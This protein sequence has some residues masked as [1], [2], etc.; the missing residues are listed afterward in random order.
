[1]VEY[2][3]I[4]DDDEWCPTNRGVY[5][6]AKQQMMEWVRTKIDPTRA[7]MLMGMS[8]DEVWTGVMEKTTEGSSTVNK[9][10]AKREKDKGGA[11]PQQE[12]EAQPRQAPPP[13]AT[14]HGEEAGHKEAGAVKED[15]AIRNTRKRE[16]RVSLAYGMR[17]GRVAK[18]EG[19]AHGGGK[20]RK[21]TWWRER[22]CLQ[23]CTCQGHGGGP[24]TRA[25]ADM[26]HVVAGECKKTKGTTEYVRQIDAAM[27]KIEKAVPR[28][29]AVRGTWQQEAR[30][31]GPM[32]GWCNARR[33]VVTAKQGTA[34]MVEG[35]KV[36]DIQW[37]AMERF[38]SDF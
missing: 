5:R 12:K 33:V 24:D 4:G 30:A 15:T 9:R 34:N 20:G 32:G 29:E 2:G 27:R 1:M 35:H 6:D 16:E 28:A 3:R 23:G 21:A 11:A 19:D 13:T 36:T 17:I 37:E 8:K 38:G 26:R 10:A 14:A 31:M 7:R 18:V 25:A 22:G